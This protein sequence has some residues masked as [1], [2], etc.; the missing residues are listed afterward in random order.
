MKKFYK[1]IGLAFTLLTLLVTAQAQPEK[2]LVDY[3]PVIELSMQIMALY[4]LETTTEQPLSVEQA[5]LLLPMLEELHTKDSMTNEE[6]TSYT[7]TLYTNVLRSEQRDWV[8]QRSSDLFAENFGSG[9]RPS[10]G[11][12]LGMRLMVGERV[13]LVKEGP[14]KDALNELTGIIS[15]KAS[16]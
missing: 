11:M 15:E 14:S 10:I 8:M 4:E 3:K 16:S 2:I 5:Q 9:K 7:E 6:A 12:G 13:N 1:Q